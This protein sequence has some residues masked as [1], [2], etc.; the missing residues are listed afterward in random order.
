MFR[1]LLVFLLPLIPSVAAAQMPPGSP[2]VGMAGGVNLAG[3]PLSYDGH[4]QFDTDA[5]GLGL[6]ALGWAFGNGFRVELEGSY[7]SNGISNIDTLRVNGRR[8]P[9]GLLQNSAPGLNTWAAMVNGAYD[10]PLANFGLA[11][12]FQPYIGAGVGF[13]WVDPSDASGVEPAIIHLPDNNT[14]TGPA[15]IS[16][17]SASAFAYQAIAGASLPI[18]L[19]PGLEAT[20]EYRFFGTTEANLEDTAVALTT[21]TINGA[22]PSG[23]NHHGTALNDNSVLLGLRYRF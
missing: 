1:K 5:G 13:A 4:V 10:I 8:Q 7:R 20:L 19:L 3:S 12:P 23:T 14:Y 16:Y 17:G 9:I 22:I 6:A 18:S 21:N 15:A 2:Y 11:W